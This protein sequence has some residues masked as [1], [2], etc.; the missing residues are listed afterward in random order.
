[1][2][3]TL[4]DFSS[5]AKSGTLNN[6]FLTSYAELVEKKEQ[7]ST[8]PVELLLQLDVLIAMMEKIRLNRDNYVTLM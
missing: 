6:L 4:K 5:I 1:M 3:A 2:I 8:N 7:G